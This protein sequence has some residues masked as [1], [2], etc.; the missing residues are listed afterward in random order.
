MPKYKTFK[1][2]STRNFYLK[3]YR[4]SIFETSE[5]KIN[6]DNN[7]DY[8]CPFCNLNCENGRSYGGHIITHKNENNFKEIVAQEKNKR[9][10]K[11]NS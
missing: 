7:E 10:A 9:N 2:N 4:K 6:E 5:K 11:H 3:H 1:Y 8:I